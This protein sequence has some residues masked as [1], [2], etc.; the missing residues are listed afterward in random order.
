MNTDER[1]IRLEEKIAYQE[2][3][4]S[5]LDEVILELNR[6]VAALQKEMGDIRTSARPID[7][8]GKQGDERPPHYGG[9]GSAV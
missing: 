2:Q 7:D 4:I 1:I 6:K 5:H 9:F 8:E 3:T